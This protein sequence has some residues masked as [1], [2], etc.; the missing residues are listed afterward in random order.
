MVRAGKEDSERNML[1]GPPDRP[2][3][4]RSF[5]QVAGMLAAAG[6]AGYVGGTVA[7]ACSRRIRSWIRGHSSSRNFRRSLSSS[8]ARAPGTAASMPAW[9]R[10]RLRAR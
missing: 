6:V 1:L 5:L 7:G 10:S 4:R 3:G 9:N 8:I 2:V